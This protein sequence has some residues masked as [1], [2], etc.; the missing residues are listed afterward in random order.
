V[1]VDAGIVDL[2]KAIWA[3]DVD[4]TMSC[5]DNM[6]SVWIQMHL[7]Q[8]QK[9]H[10]MSRQNDDLAFFLDNC[11]YSM[12]CWTPEHYAY[13]FDLPSAPSFFSVGI[14]FPKQHKDLLCSLLGK[15]KPLPWC[16]T[17]PG[18]KRRRT[19]EGAD[20]EQR[21]SDEIASLRQQLADSKRSWMVAMEG[22]CSLSSHCK[23]VLR[24][25]S[26][27]RM[28]AEEGITNIMKRVWEPGDSDSD[29][30]T[31]TDS[32]DSGAEPH[33]CNSCGIKQ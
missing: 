26:K 13:Q 28:S 7:E 21:E 15:V 32:D 18:S 19:S 1:E 30:D 14:R 33:I 3:L 6:G 2:L 8:F 4:T 17:L 24:A 16:A 5:E 10:A 31:D 22:F 11:N 29:S 23:Q 20:T 25:V 9:L 12:N 27:K